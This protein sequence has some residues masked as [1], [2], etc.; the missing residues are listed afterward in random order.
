[1][2]FFSTADE[3]AQEIYESLPPKD[4]FIHIYICKDVY[5]YGERLLLLMQ[6]NG[7][8]IIDIKYTARDFWAMIIFK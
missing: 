3:E 8:E 4:G 6:K 5:K 1:M 2:A 7:Y